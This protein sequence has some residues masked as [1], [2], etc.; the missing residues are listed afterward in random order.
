MAR[1]VAL[2][3]IALGGGSCTL[4]GGCQKGWY[5]D[6]DGSCAPY[7]CS[8]PLVK[9]DSQC[10]PSNFIYPDGGDAGECYFDVEGGYSADTAD[11]V[12]YVTALDGGE[13]DASGGGDG[14]GGGG[15]NDGGESDGVAQETVT[16]VVD[17]VGATDAD[18]TAPAPVPCVDNQDGGWICD[19]N[20]SCTTDTCD[21]AT[22]I[23]TFA[24]K[25]SGCHDG[26]PCTVDHCQAK[27]TTFACHHELVSGACDDLDP[28]TGPG[29]CVGA[30]CVAQPLNCADSNPCTSDSCQ[31]GCQNTALEG[32]CDLDGSVCTADVCVGTVCTAAA[33]NACDDGNA[34]TVDACNAATGCS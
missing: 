6:L 10:V 9:V 27:G 12:C 21:L 15:G 13:L 26:K 31:A 5:R 25:D 3:A 20:V 22:K 32:P 23:C 16:E 19:D 28:C 1:W 11:G 24:P 33:P 29:T 8:L 34:C 30:N 2:W 7:K 14:D 18:A 17:D 4:D